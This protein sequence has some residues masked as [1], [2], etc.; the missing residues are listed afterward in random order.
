MS[1]KSFVKK[2]IL[3]ERASSGAYVE[4]LRNKGVRIG[5]RVI[6]YAPT[7][8]II[9]ETR[10]WL[11][12]I[13]NDVKITSGVTILTHGYDWS[14][15]AGLHDEVL[16]SSGKVTIGNN[17]FIGMNS[18]ILK[19]VSIGNNVIIGAN[20]LV[21]KDVPDNVVVAGNPA[22]IITTVDEYYKKRKNAQKQE[23]IELYK[24]YVEVYGKEPNKEV[25]SEFFWL[26][27]TKDEAMP[28]VFKW[29]MS[30]HGREEETVNNLYKCK[31]EFNGYNDFLEYLRNS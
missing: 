5:E 31:P 23:A 11:V 7:K 27:Q 1:V 18:T 8:T 17:V 15:L 20:S 2:L 4:Y 14:V 9:D 13:G 6:I 26:F 16:G 24:N 19:G 28:N 25:F 10:P 30:H 3:K 12:E 21:N 29:Q 22:K